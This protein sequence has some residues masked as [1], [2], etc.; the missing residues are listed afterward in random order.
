MRRRVVEFILFIGAINCGSVCFAID[1]SGRQRIG[2][3]SFVIELKRGI[4][5]NKVISDAICGYFD[6]ENYGEWQSTFERRNALFR[7]RVDRDFYISYMQRA[8]E[9]HV[10]QE[11]VITGAKIDAKR[12][13]L[14]VEFHEARAKTERGRLSSYGEELEF[15]K[16]DGVWKCRSCGFRGRFGINRPIIFSSK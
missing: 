4:T 11:L 7:E 3:K 13:L 12:A 8:R 10:I 6:A 1:D 2:C 14:N 9:Q 16:E 5:E 15:V